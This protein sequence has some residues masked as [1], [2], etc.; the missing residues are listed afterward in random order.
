MT[1]PALTLTAPG[2][3]VWVDVP[4]PRLEGP[5]EALVRPVAVATCGLDTEIN[6]GDFPLP[7]PYALGHEFVGEVVSVGDTVTTVAPGDLVAVPFQISCG[8]CRPCQRGLTAS[9]ISV[10]RGSAYGLGRIGG[11][12]WGGAMTE[13]VRVPYADAM[14]L[15]V[16][17]GVAPESIASLDNLA[18]GWRTVGPYLPDLPA[19]ERRVLIIG[20][21]SVGLYAAGFAR[22]LGAAVTYVDPDPRRRGVADTWGATIG[23]LESKARERYPV[24]VCAQGSEISLRQTLSATEPGGVCV[25]CGVFTGDVALPIN[26][27]Y[28]TGVQ[29]VTGRVSARAVMPAVLDLA[30]QGRIDPARVTDTTASW[31]EAPAAW[32]T[33]RDKLVVIR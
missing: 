6:A 26:R 27:M 32:S 28:T 24:T 21:S 25:N 3:A 33:H 10:P 4:E 8:V 20:A 17:D 31:D 13:L 7:L 14:L 23:D 22:A 29:F 2:R 9:C 11:D 15:P 5:G 1:M 19:D 12:A 18:D 16:P 30:A